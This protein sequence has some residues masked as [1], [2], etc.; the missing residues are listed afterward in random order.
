MAPT[1]HT[2]LAEVEVMPLIVMEPC[3][4]LGAM[5]GNGDVLQRV[6]S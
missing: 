2:S 1:A 6:P 4:G 3:P 5:A